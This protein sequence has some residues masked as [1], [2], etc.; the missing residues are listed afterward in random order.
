[1][2]QYTTL[3]VMD[4]TAN[5]WMIWF[6]GYLR[7]VLSS[8]FHANAILIQYFCIQ[9][10]IK[11]IYNCLW[12]L[13]IN[14][15]SAMILH[16]HQSK[17]PPSGKFRFN[18]IVCGNRSKRIIIIII[19]WLP[20]FDGSIAFSVIIITSHHIIITITIIIIVVVVVVVVKKL[21]EQ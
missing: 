1:M 9:R 18:F 17:R 14:Q 19:E 3:R 2:V 11:Q 15:N 4:G 7:F 13:W 12:K 5:L 21:R 10:Q 20:F 6:R 16:R 8:Q